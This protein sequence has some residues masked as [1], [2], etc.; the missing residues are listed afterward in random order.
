MH[1]QGPFN[2]EEK[3]RLNDYIINIRGKRRIYHAN[4]LKKYFERKTPTDP[5][6]VKAAMTLNAASAEIINHDEETEVCQD[7]LLDLYS[8]RQQTETSKDIIL[9]EELRNQHKTAERV[10]RKI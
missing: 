8:G 1:W 9:G 6:V 5:M 2:I 7:D 4:M 3:V 10:T